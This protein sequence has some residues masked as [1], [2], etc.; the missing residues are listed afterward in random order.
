MPISQDQQ[1]FDNNDD[2]LLANVSQELERF[3]KT[4]FLIDKAQEKLNELEA[5]R[6]LVDKDDDYNFK[7]MENRYC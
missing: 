2:K 6:K 1:N 5:E 3:K 7:L 4:F